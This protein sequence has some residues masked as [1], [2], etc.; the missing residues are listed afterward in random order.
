MTLIKYLIYE[1]AIDILYSRIQRN[2]CRLKFNSVNLSNLRIKQTFTDMGEP[3]VRYSVYCNGA[4]HTFTLSTEMITHMK[5]RHG[6]DMD[7][8]ILSMIEH[9]IQHNMNNK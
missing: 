7:I 8:E 5:S 6:L 9:E 1:F 3:A 4:E 2:L